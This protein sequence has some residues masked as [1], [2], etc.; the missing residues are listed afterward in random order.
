M[1]DF[2]TE[3]TSALQDISLGITAAAAVDEWSANS[4]LGRFY[5]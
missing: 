2:A 3:V 5:Q 1:C 4:V